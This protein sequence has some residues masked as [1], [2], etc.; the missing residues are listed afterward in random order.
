MGV[1]YHV[2]VGPVLVCK[3]HQNDVVTKTTKQER[4]CP[5]N[6][7]SDGA[8]CSK[9]GLPATTKTVEREHTKKVKSVDSFYDI[10]SEGGFREDTFDDCWGGL[11]CEEFVDSCDTLAPQVDKFNELLGRKTNLDSRGFVLHFQG[12]LNAKDEMKKCEEFFAKEIALLR[13]KYDSVTVDWMILTTG[14]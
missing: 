8:F 1:D 6:H 2:Y 3:Y 13:S 14:R 10:M 11:N 7:K 5:N 9:C 4:R 12:E